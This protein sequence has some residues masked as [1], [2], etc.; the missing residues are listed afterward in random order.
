LLVSEDEGCGMKFLPPQPGDEGGTLALYS[1][2]RSALAAAYRV[3]EVKDI[4]D[5]AVAMQAYARQ[6]Q[7]A[8]LIEMATEIRLRAERRAGQLLREIEKASG[9]KGNPGGRGAKIVRSADATAQK[10]TLAELGINKNQ[11]ARWQKLAELDEAAFELKA[12]AAKKNMVASV[13]KDTREEVAREKRERRASRE[14]ELGSRIVALPQR[15]YGVILADPE[16]QFDVWSRETGMD[17]AADNHYPTSSLEA[18]LS[19]D[20]TSIAADD[21]VLFL[22][23]TAPMQP[24]AFAVMSAWGFI[25]R[26]QVI[27]VKDRL[28]TGYWFRNKHELLLVG[29]RGKVP[30][31]AMGTQ[32]PS[33]VEAP[34]GAHSAKPEK[35]L[36]LIESYFPTLPKIELNRRGPARPGWDA[37]GNEAEGRAA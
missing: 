29:T 16:W 32:W 20:I 6:A 13:D 9:A 33:V 12:T 28:G 14:T 30:A 26:S 15:R 37:W 5:K 8:A 31:P 22:W 4:R 25:Y 23:S 17:R 11:S 27:W 7:D 35:F 34:V 3:D 10:P 19:R 21:C 18:I 24:Q 36:E 1:A 2:A